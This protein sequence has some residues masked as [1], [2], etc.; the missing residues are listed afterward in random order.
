MKPAAACPFSSSFYAVIKSMWKYHAD[1]DSCPD[2]VSQIFPLFRQGG[3]A[4]HVQDTVLSFWNRESSKP[5]AVSH[6]IWSQE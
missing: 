6:V 1:S 3:G 5:V 2:F 4:D